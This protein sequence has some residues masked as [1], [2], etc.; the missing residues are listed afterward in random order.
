MAYGFCITSAGWDLIGRLVASANDAG[1]TPVLRFSRVAFGK[2]KTPPNVSPADLTDVVDFVA[3]GTSSTP[4]VKVFRREDGTVEKTTISFFVQYR[5]GLAMEVTEGFWLNEFALMVFDNA[6]S[7]EVGVYR[8]DLAEFPQYVMPFVSGSVDVRT[9]DVIITI[10]DEL[11]VTIEY[12]PLA[13]ITDEDMRRY[14]NE[15]CKPAFLAL[16]QAQVDAHNIRELE[17]GTE[18]VVHPPLQREINSLRNRISDMEQMLGGQG[19]T[20]FWYDFTSLAGIDL[21]KGVWN[22]D[23]SRVEF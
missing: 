14:A 2:G 12:S 1:E 10:T 5:S 16:S 3:N 18:P 11:E 21:I 8:G 6:N 17:D 9:F 22:V 23:E 7:A 4:F 19:S 15:E 13:F 20:S